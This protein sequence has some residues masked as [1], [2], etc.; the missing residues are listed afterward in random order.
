MYPPTD[1]FGVLTER[2]ARLTLFDYHMSSGICTY[3]FCFV[4]YGTFGYVWVLADQERY[5]RDQLA[6]FGLADRKTYI[7]GQFITFGLAD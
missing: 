2:C 5:I 4:T 3:R 7:C 1:V 6:T